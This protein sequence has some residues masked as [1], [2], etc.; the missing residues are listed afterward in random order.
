MMLAAGGKVVFAFGR[1][2]Q[3]D[4]LGDSVPEIV[5]GAR[6]RVLQEGF[7]FGECDFDGIEVRAIGRQA[8]ELCAGTFDRLSDSDRFVGGQVVHHHDVAWQESRRQDLFDI[9]EERGTVHGAIQDHRR[10]H[11]L[12]PK[13]ADEGHGLPMALRNGRSATFATQSASIAPGHLGRC[14][15]FIDEHQPLRLEID[16]GIEP[17]LSP[18]QDIRPLL[19][20]SVCGFF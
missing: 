7:D 19:L 10:C 14:A 13:R 20:G 12:Q 9:G 6:N 5:D 8:A 3:I 1:R 15:R 11:A 17:G 16:L 2:E 18:T 4:R